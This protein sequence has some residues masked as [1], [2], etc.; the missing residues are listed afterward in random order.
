M[1]LRIFL[2]S[3]WSALLMT[4]LS[5]SKFKRTFATYVLLQTVLFLLCIVLYHV[6]WCFWVKMSL[7]A[8]CFVDVFTFL[9]A[10]HNFCQGWLSTMCFPFGKKPHNNPAVNPVLGPAGLLPSRLFLWIWWLL[11]LKCMHFGLKND[12]FKCVENTQGNTSFIP[13]FKYI[14]NK[15]LCC[16]VIIKF[17]SFSVKRSP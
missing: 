3:V 17:V 4:E 8:K 11:F 1:L 10:M 2:S 16:F 9:L 6:Q 14:K 7:N 5:G 13:Q 12:P 15:E